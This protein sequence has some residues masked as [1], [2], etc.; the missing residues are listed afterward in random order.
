MIDVGRVRFRHCKRQQLDADILQR[1]DFFPATPP[2]VLV[3]C[4]SIARRYC[5]DFAHFLSEN[6]RNRAAKVSLSVQN[7]LNVLNVLNVKTLTTKEIAKNT[8]IQKNNT[9]TANMTN[10]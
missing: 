4:A 5:S 7:V 9:K 10:G 3:R 2:E 8:K 1:Q 6:L